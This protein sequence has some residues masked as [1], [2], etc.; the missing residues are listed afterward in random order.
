MSKMNINEEVLNSMIIKEF[1]TLDTDKSG[2]IDFKEYL[3][4]V[5]KKFKEF[6]LGD[7]ED[8]TIEAQMKTI[9]K[10]GDS[11]ISREEYRTYFRQLMD[12]N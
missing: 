2:F 8:A 7:L 9:D 11:K 12:L 5:K 1:D 6:D 3:Q 10:D 4:S